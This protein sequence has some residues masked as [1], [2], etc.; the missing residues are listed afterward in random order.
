FRSFELVQDRSGSGRKSMFRIPRA[1]SPP[2]HF[3]PGLKKIRTELYAGGNPKYTALIT[4]L[5]RFLEDRENIKQGESSQDFRGH[6]EAYYIDH[7][8]FAEADPSPGI[9]KLLENAIVARNPIR[10]TYSGY[11]PESGESLFYPYSLCLRVGTLYLVGRQGANQGP[12]KSLSVK[13][14]KRCIGTRDVFVRDPFDPAEYYKYCFGQWPRQLDEAPETV[15]LSLRAPWLEKYLSE[16][17]FNPPGR[18]LRKG[19]D[20]F[21]E[22]KIAIKP[23]F[24]NWVISLSP[25]L[26]AVKPDGLRREVA[27]R[28]SKGLDRTEAG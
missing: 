23:D 5:I 12:F 26:V 19:K 21:F 6:A 10:L 17:H 3:L 27:E 7:G 24:V 15:L 11:S 16:S 13:R 20:A 9:L 4:Q 1:E 8:P 18:I 28:L 2:E 14:I 25:D 22:V